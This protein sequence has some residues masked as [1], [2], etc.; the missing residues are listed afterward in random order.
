MSKA[1]HQ[2]LNESYI[3]ATFASVRHLLDDTTVSELMLNPYS[4]KKGQVWVIRTNGVHEK[5]KSLGGDYIYWDN[6]KTSQ[7]FQLL[8]GQNDKITHSKRPILECN[9]PILNY[10]FTGV[11]QPASKMSHL[12]CIR[13]FTVRELTFED[14]VKQGLLENEHVDILRQ[15]IKYNFNVLLCGVMFSGK[16]TFENTYIA[17]ILSQNSNERIIVIE[18]TPELTWKQG[19]NVASLLCSNEVNTDDHIK[20]SMRLT[21]QRIVVGEIRDRAAY[22]L[23]K[24]WGTGHRGGITSMHAGSVAE[25]MSRLEK[26]CL[27]HNECDKIDR[28]DLARVIDGIIVMNVKR[29][30][31][32][33]D[34]GRIAFDIKRE[35]S[36]IV[37]LT[38]YDTAHGKWTF[39]PILGDIVN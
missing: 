14:Y 30:K 37:E 4:D 8:S 22:S 35:I 10:R 17:E 31:R 6:M 36:Q 32:V 1:D 7:L 28:E 11:L 25:G 29:V 33:T 34:D 38:G 5:A 2:E 23:Y 16:T 21:G 20:T 13:K 12:F 15:W 27:E 9:I 39:K 3:N 18:D 26:M 24:V 19:S